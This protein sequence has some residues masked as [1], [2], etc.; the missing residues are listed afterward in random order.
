MPLPSN[1]GVNSGVSAALQRKMIYRNRS[2]S[3][4]YA[5]NQALLNKAANEYAP[6]QAE[7]QAR[8][9]EQANLMNKAKSRK[10]HKSRKTRKSRKSKN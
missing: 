5:E 6:S 3:V 9:R 4:G 1:T 10:T 8:V 2:K 7:L